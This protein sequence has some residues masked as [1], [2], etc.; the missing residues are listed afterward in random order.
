MAKRNV[1]S[2]QNLGGIGSIGAA[3]ANAI[4]Q[5]SRTASGAARQQRQQRTPGPLYRPSGTTPG[6]T[7]GGNPMMSGMWVNVGGGAPDLGAAAQQA[8][9]DAMRDFDTEINRDI[10]PE[11][12][13]ALG[14][15]LLGRSVNPKGFGDEIMQRQ[16]TRLSEREASVRESGMGQ[17]AT[18][19]GA[20]SRIESVR[21]A[22]R[23][24]SASRLSSA[25]LDLLTQDAMLAAQNKGIDVPAAVQL[26]LADAGLAQSAA[27][28]KG[29]VHRPLTGG[30]GMQPDG[31]LLGAGGAPLIR[32]DGSINVGDPKN[33]LPGESLADQIRRE[34]QERAQAQA[35]WGAIGGT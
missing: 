6:Y 8:F 25:E 7:A 17:L 1:G 22:L 28:F 18:M 35:G 19:R 4:S 13:G 14:Q 11:R 21:N 33:R 2:Y 12:F 31:S 15:A 30:G 10:G 27:M 26:A 29:S 20:P 23:G 32:A 9:Q 34:A 24:E 5:A 16:M 3:V